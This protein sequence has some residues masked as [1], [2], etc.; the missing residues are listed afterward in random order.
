MA[1]E[2]QENGVSS[3]ELVELL[4]RR[5]TIDEWISGW[6]AQQGF[7]GMQQPMHNKTNTAIHKYRKNCLFFVYGQKIGNHLM[8][9]G[10]TLTVSHWKTCWPL[11]PSLMY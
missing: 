10:S 1:Q 8:L 4:A 5:I 3:P 9:H 11:L 2:K 7:V 6:V